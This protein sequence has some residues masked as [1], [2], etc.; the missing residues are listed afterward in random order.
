MFNLSREKFILLKR[1]VII[2]TIMVFLSSCLTIE[3]NLKLNA[4]GSGNIHISY[5]M[6]KGLKGISTLGSQDEIV[7]LNLSEEYIS[8][9]TNNNEDITYKD[10][11]ISEDEIYY[12][13][14]VTFE[15]ETIEALNSVF[16]EENSVKIERI[17]NETVFTQ[18]IVGKSDEALSTETREIFKD[19]FKDHSFTLKVRVPGDIIS[20]E[21]GIKSEN[22]LAIYQESFIDV[23]NNPSLNSWSIRW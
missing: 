17:G 12:R 7:P 22:R 11:K 5:I 21:N 3:S 9:I 23:I 15:F 2:L 20:I 1:L 18:V 6:D 19:I 8:E 10:Y 4:N 14:D 13:V 16:P